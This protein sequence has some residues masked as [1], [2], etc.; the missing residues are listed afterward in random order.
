MSDERLL[1][2]LARLARTTAGQDDVTL[3]WERLSAGALTPDEREALR[4]QAETSPQA[5]AAWDAFR[6]LDVEER[7][8]LVARLRQELPARPAPAR[9][10]PLRRAP[11][12]LRL[13]LVPTLAAAGLLVYFQPWSGPDGLPPYELRLGGMTRAERSAEPSADAS[14]PLVFTRGNRFELLLT[15]ATAA[16][17]PLEARAFVAGDAGL[18]ALP[19]PD[20]QRSAD[21][22]LRVTGVVG[23]DVRLPEGDSTLVVVLGRPG[24][25]PAAAELQARLADADAA[26]DALWSAWKLRLRAPAEP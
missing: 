5:A 21:G 6:P 8:D 12:W 11:A 10:V 14:A 20:G 2:D 13:G 23:Q 16:R 4:R 22:V 9:V 18:T 15:P 19:M 26:R 7:E 3:D 1:H 25:L 17:G 24:A